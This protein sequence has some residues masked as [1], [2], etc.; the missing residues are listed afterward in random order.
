[1][2]YAMMSAKYMTESVKRWWGQKA[3][4]AEVSARVRQTRS[5]HSTRSS[6]RFVQN[7]HVL[8]TLNQYLRCMQACFLSSFTIVSGC[9]C[10]GWQFRL[11]LKVGPSTRQRNPQMPLARLII[12][13][14]THTTSD[15][16]AQG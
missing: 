11:L 15:I 14:H 12:S 1:M 9:S 5:V 3:G 8:D 6:E 13:R 16:A 10:L 2:S 7:H 4:S